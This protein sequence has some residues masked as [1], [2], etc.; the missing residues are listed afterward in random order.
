[1][2]TFFTIIIAALVLAGVACWG[3]LAWQ[4]VKAGKGLTAP[5]AALLAAVLVSLLGSGVFD[6]LKL[7]GASLATFVV[8]FY[9]A[10]HPYDEAS[11]FIVKAAHAV[12]TGVVAA[13]N[14][15]K[16]LFKKKS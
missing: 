12:A 2:I 9:F 10:T 3:V 13:W 15:V 11:S 5:V 14:W 4:A 1:M 8:G 7:F 16:N 6:G